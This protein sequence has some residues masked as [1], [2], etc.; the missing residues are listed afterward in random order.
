MGNFT[1]IIG[2]KNNS[3]W[4]LR[5]YLALKHA[6]VEFDEIMIALRPKLDREKLDKLTPAGKVPTLIDGKEY[7][8]DSLAIA[9]YMNDLYPE[10]S[11]WPKDIKTRAHA[12]SVS[13]EM[14]SGFVALRKNMPMACHSI[15][16]CPEI[17][18]DLKR[19][20]DR[21][22]KIWSDC[23][24]KYSK[25][26]PYLFGKY[27]IADMMFAPVVFRFR[28]YQVELPK[29]LQNYCQLM[30]NHPDIKSWLDDADPNDSAE[31]DK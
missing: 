15:F 9:E 16:E 1:L 19:D 3:T 30:V 8:W 12:R 2:N 14:H 13:A 6:G 11:F 23:L 21:V 17:S 5:G 22:K 27:S 28:S 20:I 26:G 4:S 24:A 7:I 25:D 31:A 10:K 18:G 29:A